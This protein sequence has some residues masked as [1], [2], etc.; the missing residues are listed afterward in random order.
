MHPTHLHRATGARIH[1]LT[2][3]CL[4]GEVMFLIVYLVRGA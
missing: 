3:L 2:A 1:A 4:A